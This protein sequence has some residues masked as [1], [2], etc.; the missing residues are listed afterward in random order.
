[1]TML[2]LDLQDQWRNTHAD[3][4]CT[5]T[6]A[7][8]IAEPIADVDPICQ[9]D[10]TIIGT[11]QATEAALR[12]NN[13][14]VRNLHPADQRDLHQQ[15]VLQAD[16]GVQLLPAHKVELSTPLKIMETHCLQMRSPQALS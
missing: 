13:G 15:Q 7:S 2:C 5:N 11:A 4:F 6:Y 9:Q 8:T 16:C 10:S 3:T 14:G 12:P 1:M